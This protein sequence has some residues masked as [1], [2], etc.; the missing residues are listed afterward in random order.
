[1]Y[2]CDSTDDRGMLA[3]MFAD[4]LYIGNCAHPFSFTLPTY[5]NSSFSQILLQLRNSH[6][7]AETEAEAETSLPI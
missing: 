2:K 7:E 1:M 6:I 3:L 4:F 5:F